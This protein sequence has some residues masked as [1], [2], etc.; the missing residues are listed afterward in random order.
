MTVT[1]VIFGNKNPKSWFSYLPFISVDTVAL[2]LFP[3]SPTLLYF[4]ACVLA[5]SSAQQII[6]GIYV[7]HIFASFRKAFSAYS[8]V[9]T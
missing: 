1:S 3:K 5:V 7:T 4:R 6:F 2:L 8:S 9:H